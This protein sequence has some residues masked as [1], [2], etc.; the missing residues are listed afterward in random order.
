M[1]SIGSFTSLVLQKNNEADHK[2][3][4]GGSVNS[5]AELMIAKA[6][7]LARGILL[8]MFLIIASYPAALLTVIIKFQSDEHEQM[9]INNHINFLASYLPQNGLNEITFREV[10]FCIQISIVE[11]YFRLINL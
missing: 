10:F 11:K 3:A 1:K 9:F 7:L 5:Y 2:F 4:S 6:T 8:A